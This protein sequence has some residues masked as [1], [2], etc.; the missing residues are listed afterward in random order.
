MAEVSDAEVR[1]G[2]YFAEQVWDAFRGLHAAHHVHSGGE[3]AQGGDLPAWNTLTD[4]NQLLFTRDLL[5]VVGPA[6]NV[7][8]HAVVRHG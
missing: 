7:L 2:M 4:R 1:A 8:V 5:R 3:C 6:V